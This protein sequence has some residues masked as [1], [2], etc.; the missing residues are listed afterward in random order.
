[1]KVWTKLCLM[2][3]LPFSI[4]QG[5]AAKPPEAAPLTGGDAISGDPCLADKQARVVLE[6]A[7]AEGL[8]SLC[9]YRTALVANESKHVYRGTGEPGM[10]FP[11]GDDKEK[12][13]TQSEGTGGNTVRLIVYSGMLIPT[14]DNAAVADVIRLQTIFPTMFKE[15]GFAADERV[16]YTPSG[17]DNEKFAFTNYRFLKQALDGLKTLDYEGTVK[18]IDFGS[19]GYV[20]LDKLTRDANSGLKEYGGILLIYPLNGQTAVVGRSEQV[21]R[22]ENQEPSTLISERTSADAASKDGAVR[23]SIKQSMQRDFKNYQMAAKAKE[24][25]NEKR[26]EFSK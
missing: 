24:V 9:G 10:L 15:K 5:C 22:I 11:G 26:A 16:T 21:L 20:V 14:T 2:A 12:P 3:V 8:K 17:Q 23:A 6:G 7:S 25:M 4:L 19:G 13:V 1:M 18:I